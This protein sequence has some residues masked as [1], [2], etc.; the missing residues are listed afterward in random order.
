MLL[1]QYSF[2]FHGQQEKTMPVKHKQ[3]SPLF[4]GTALFICILVVNIFGSALAQDNV[5]PDVLEV[6]A[7]VP[8]EFPPYY[9]VDD[10]GR[11]EGFAIDILDHIAAM[12]GLRV[13]YLVEDSWSDVENAVKSGRAVLI[14]NI[15]FSESR[16][17][18]LDYTA[19]I[20][21]FPISIFV[22][23]Y[24]NDIGG[25][26]DLMGRKVGAVKFNAGVDLLR[27]R[28]QNEIKV[29]NDPREALL[30]LL[31]GHVDAVVYP[32]PVFLKLAREAGLERRIRVAGKPL[33]EIKRAIGVAEG[34]MELLKR[35]DQAV[36]SFVGTKDYERV[37]K[38]W[39]GEPAPFWSTTRVFLVVVGIGLA[40]FFLM[41]GWRHYSLI[42]S[43]LRLST[44]TTER[45]LVEEALRETA[46]ELQGLIQASP[47]AI[48][49][50]DPD[51]NVTLWNPAAERLFGWREA[52][53]L[54]QFLP[55]ISDDKREEHRALRESVLRGEGFTGVEVRRRR[56][57]GS[58]VDISVS[59][60]PM[61]DAEGNI[62]GIMSVNVDITERARQTREIKLLNRL[63][64][65]LSRVS[66]AVVR[67]TSPGMF[68]EQACRE[69]VEGGGFLLSWI[70]YVEPMTNAVV[71]TAF[72]GGIGEYVQGI[73]VYAD[74]RPE[75]CGPT[76][77]CIRQQRTV[78]H[79]DFLHDPQN[80]PWRDR[81]T[82]FGIASAAAFPIER[83]GRVWGALTI[84]S[85]EV[86]RFGDEDVN[87]LEKVAGDIG[88]AL[89]NLDREFQR[90]LAE[91][92]LLETKE[93]LSIFIRHSPFYAYIK[94]VT[95]SESRVMQ[96]S[97][98]YLE[99]IGIRGSE[100]IGKTMPELFPVDFAAKIT[101]DDWAVV[102]SGTVSNHEE[103][104]NG[105]DYT[106]IKFPIMLEGKTLLA[107]YT[108]DIT[109]Q[110]RTE[111]ELREMTGRLNLATASAKAG[112]W[113]WNL[114]A[115]EMIWD[116]RMFE[117]YGLTRENFPG[118][119]EAWQQGLHPDDSSRAIE[120]CQAA[121]D[122]QRDFNTEF[123]VRHPDGT[124]VHI[125][126]NGL[127]LRDEKGKPLRMIGLNIDVTERKHAE[128]AR[129]SLEERLQRAEKMEALG[130]LAGGVAHDLNNVLGVV[131]GYSEMLLD[132]FG[133]PSSVKSDATEILKAG[134]RAAGIVQDLLTLTRRGVQSRKVLNLNR[135]IMDCQKTPE[136]ANVLSYHS[137]IEIKMDLESD[138]LNVSGSSIHLGKSFMNLIS[139]A[140]EAM[141][142]GGTLTVK[143]ANV[144]LDKPIS[145]YDEV[146]EGDYVVL[147]VSDT[148]EG[149]PAS[150]LKRIF[151]PFYTK[152]VM[153][154]SG[155]GLGLAVV[156]G[157]VKDH[158]GYVNLE[159]EEGKGTTFTL[160]FPVTREEISAEQV[161]VPV[162]EYMGNGESILIVDD[163]KEQRQIAAKMLTKLKYMVATVSGGAEAVEYLKQNAVDL[164]VLDMIMDPGMDG[165]DTYRK[166]LEV[167]PH[168][169]AIIVSGF[170]ETERVSTAKALGAGAYVKK[171]YVLEKLGL[172]VRNELDRL[173]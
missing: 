78:V 34:N 80:L 107:G 74:N 149:I 68:L 40:L 105:R 118:G 8:R 126:A 29:F 109:E 17:V 121:L 131:V 117:L 86:D 30:E 136:F 12:S 19:P 143:S 90:K 152:K 32:G 127:V 53:V 144:Y 20:E 13:T 151:E 153:G 31:A 71:P 81:A 2:P 87:L 163:V 139:N 170:S 15:G 83:A 110:K 172:A 62:T 45:E 167:H 57:D 6:T 154:R 113:D 54:G 28:A 63:Y 22:R 72:W 114:E 128:E 85:D 94:E 35:L 65:V 60:A 67:A 166:I 161:S 76:G 41:A 141:P 93:L 77:T 82:P 112:V 98:N 160:Y 56:K 140:A 7:A 97:D 132:D 73:T 70:G 130:T 61:R 135:I 89:D 157:T 49:S 69:V 84:Y 75:G 147:S 37:F 102:S 24:T 38:K 21:T 101:T 164:V 91:E 129:R 115:N 42:K 168:Q 33:K 134:Q 66:Q 155:T 23:E 111:K 16:D 150:D 1:P 123:R 122:G 173:A 169:K 50:F 27:E 146:R 99:M 96:A 148:G 165:L 26:D 138:L 25:V 100:M 18:W 14:P 88:F 59:T 92:L 43:N 44:S 171:P 11:P 137:N 3:T 106:T 51:G 142:N 36:N 103:S 10:R 156:W 39:F 158:H 159:S 52:E 124:V 46:E 125:E 64:S 58:T 9:G 4:S 162:A 5:R 108:I 120:E 48:I 79:N 119:I 104:L 55:Y 145:G 133:D 47:A 116:D 95:P